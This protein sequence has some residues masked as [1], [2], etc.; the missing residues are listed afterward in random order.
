VR[1]WLS[2][3][4]GPAEHHFW[5]YVWPGLVAA[6]RLAVWHFFG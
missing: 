5:L 3:E 1:N 4:I 2:K 6:A